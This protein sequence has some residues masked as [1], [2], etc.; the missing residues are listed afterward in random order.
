MTLG[1]TVGMKIAVSIPDGLFQ[2]A[3]KLAQDLDIS[4]SALYAKALKEMLARIRDEAITAEINEALKVAP[5]ESDPAIL[6][7]NLARLRRELEANGGQ[8]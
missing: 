2:E 5:Y 3:E 7:N 8:W 6:R 1:Y 4:R